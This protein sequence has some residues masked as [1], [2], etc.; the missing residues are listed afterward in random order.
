[1]NN[2]WIS[3][4]STF[5]FARA[6]VVEGVARSLDIGGTLQAYNGSQSGQEADELALKAD[7]HAIGDD[8]R[9]AIS[10][11]SE[12]EKITL[13]DEILKEAQAMLD[14]S[15]NVT[16]LLGEFTENAETKK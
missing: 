4:W 9:R 13:S 2:K 10:D 12:E 11:L 5:L 16:A 3:T 7:F 8:L 14:S 1:M 15:L 6:S